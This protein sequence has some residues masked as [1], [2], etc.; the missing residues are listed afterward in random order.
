VGGTITIN[1]DGSMAI[2]PNSGA[3]GAVGNVGFYD[4]VLCYSLS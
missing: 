3:F 2:A 1:P 4:Q